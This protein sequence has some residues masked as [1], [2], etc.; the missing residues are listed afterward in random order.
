MNKAL[1]LGSTGLVGGILLE[2]LL[3]DDYFNEVTVWV[4]KPSSIKHPKLKEVVTDFITLPNTDAN[5][6]FSC[7]GTTQKK[8][9]DP[10]AYYFIEVEI[11][12][13]TAKQTQLQQF[14]YV[15]SI[16]ASSKAS[17]TYLKN[18]WEAES[19]LSSLNIPSVYLYRPS[20]IVG[21]RNE[22][23]LAEGIFT[24]LAPLINRLLWGGLKKYR[25][26]KAET[27]A[28]AML[29]NSKNPQKGNFVVESDK[30][31]EIGG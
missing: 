3:N 5:V 4:R 26:I 1:V 11:P 13:N 29:K 22:K 24:T 9:P 19:K 23:R 10:Q 17:A 25:S 7:L 6:V 8:T 14:H 12:V 20:L 15:S 31:E 16:G 2:K 27:I 28:E 21:Q 30:I 18:K